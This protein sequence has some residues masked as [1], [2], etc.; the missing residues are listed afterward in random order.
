[1]ARVSVA[2]AMLG[3]TKTLG[4]AYVN[5]VYLLRMFLKLVR[6][7]RLFE[8]GYLIIFAGNITTGCVT[9][10]GGRCPRNAHGVYNVNFK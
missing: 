6:C 1:M 7:V 3:T 8:H 4:Q 5:V 2:F 10:T 9:R